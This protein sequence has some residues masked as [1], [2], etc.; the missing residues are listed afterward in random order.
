MAEKSQREAKKRVTELVKLIDYHRERYHVKDAPEIS[1]EAYDSLVRELEE[2]ERQYPEL[3]KADSP[4]KV[5]GAQSSSA[6][7]KVTHRV[8]QWSFDNAFSV[9]ELREWEK[10]LYRF[11]EKEDVAGTRLTYVA[12]HKID[13]LKVILE[14]EKGKLVRAATRGDGVVGEDVTHTASAIR[15][16]PKKLKRDVDV[17][18]VGEAWLKASELERINAL[19]KKEGQPLFANTRNAAAGSLRQLDA[20][21][22]AKR[23]LSFF[24]YDIDYFEAQGAAARAPETQEEELLLLKKLGFVVSSHYQRCE[25][26]DDVLA[27]YDTWKKRHDSLP[28]GVDG[29]VVKVN[30]LAL[31]RVLG[32]TAKSPRF[33]IAYKFPAVQATTVVEDIQLQVGRTGV[34]TPVAHLRPVLIDGS[35][36]SRATLHNEDQIKRLDV[37]VGDTIVL[38]KAGDVIPEVVSVLKELRPKNAKPYAF[39]K[40]VAECGGDGAIERV[41]GMA[42]WRCVSKDSDALHRRRLYYFVSKA[43]CNI[44]GVG[45]RIIDLLLD[46]A[47]INT[48][49]DL[50]TLKVGDLRDLPGFGEK[51]A[52][53]AIDAIDAAR[54]LPLHRVL[55]ALSIDHVGEETAR[56]IANH[57]GSI[58]A[59]RAASAEELAAIHGVGEIVGASVFAWMHDDLHTAMLDDLL[60]EIEVVNPKKSAATGKLSGKTFVF[61]G[62]LASL[63]REAASD[64]V[65]REGAHVTNSVSSATDYVVVG[66]DPGSKAEKARTLGVKIL[67]EVQFKK[68]VGG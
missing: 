36:V 17:I 42:A 24:A 34:L 15:D 61:T 59:I 68:I 7:T 8:R 31:Q 49:V 27:Y 14:Y 55:V 5:V 19:R 44:D 37:R 21:V 30:E 57:F 12:E 43:A 56:L 45:P 50:F 18:V 40:R 11:L 22:T 3:Q 29:V 51:A 23:N 4:T 26:I 13:G 47:L 25:S 9:D 54:T 67:N 2:L 20:S 32:H 35:T 16:I 65:R 52:Q 48:S 63:S 10:R 39:P 38:Q 64:M 60:A 6:F 58:K 41:P 53:N 66:E 62:T 1:D 28:Y 46:N 33:G